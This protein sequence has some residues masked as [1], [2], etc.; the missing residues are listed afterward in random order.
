LL[1]QLCLYLP[2]LLDYR[3]QMHRNQC[4][5]FSNMFD[6]GIICFAILLYLHSF[7]PRLPFLPIKCLM[8]LKRSG[9]FIPGVR[10]GVETLIFLIRWCLW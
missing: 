7:I 4:G 9:G 1:K 5:A 10:P 2:L 3:S 8:I 6:F